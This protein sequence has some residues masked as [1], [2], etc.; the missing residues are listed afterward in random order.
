MNRVLFVFLLGCINAS[1]A[2]AQ[3]I[4]GEYTTEWQWDMKKKT[5]WVNQLRL[6]L[7]IPFGN[8]KNSFEAATL[9]VAKPTTPLL[10]I[11]KDSPISKPTICLHP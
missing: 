5:N 11:G 10:M 4:S 7:N 3:N 9:H 8:G 6:D 2:R 1:L